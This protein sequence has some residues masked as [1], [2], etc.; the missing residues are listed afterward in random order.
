MSP[1]RLLRALLPACAIASAIAGC[2]VQPERQVAAAGAEPQAFRCGHERVLAHFRPGAVEL[3]LAGRSWLLPAVVAASGARYAQGDD[4]FWSR[5]TEA[6][7]RLDGVSMSCRVEALDPWRQ[8]QARGAAFRAVGQEPGWV[9][10]LGPGPG[11]GAWLVVQLDYGARSLRIEPTRRLADAAGVAGEAG[12][13][14]VELRI[15]PEPCTDVMSG[16]AF[17]MTANLRVGERS[18]AGC[19]RFLAD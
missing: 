16:E 5:G 9:A 13:E 7:L 18:L 12:G 1:T 6:R 8:A 14:A 11:P 3:V 17:E 15:S 19:G 2:A 4:E 10:E